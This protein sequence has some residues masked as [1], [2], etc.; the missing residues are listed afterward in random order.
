LSTTISGSGGT[1][2]NR[3]SGLATGIDTESMV[4]A[5]TTSTRLRIQ[6][7]EQQKQ[8]LLW[9]QEAFRTITKSVMDFKSK[10]FTAWSSSSV[11]NAGFFKQMS[12]TSSQPAYLTAT[13]NASAA[14]GEITS[15]AGR[16][17]VA[18]G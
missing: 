4:E 7:L 18:A 16:S 15:P 5:L 12:V 8:S 6:K 17:G 9:K 1:N 11:N 2:Y 10:Y 13:A 3:V 14:A